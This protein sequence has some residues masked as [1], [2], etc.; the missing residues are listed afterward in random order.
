MLYKN[1]SLIKLEN[2][3]NKVI[4]KII[5]NSFSNSLKEIFSIGMDY[6]C[7]LYRDE[8]GEYLSL[9]KKQKIKGTKGYTVTV[10]LAS[11]VAGA[12]D[13]SKKNLVQKYYL[14]KDINKFFQKEKTF[15]WKRVITWQ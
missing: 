7:Y 14:L 11:G 15:R 5:N 1:P 4:N 3:V 13:Y 12:K 10:T 9:F 8:S 6:Q 2:S